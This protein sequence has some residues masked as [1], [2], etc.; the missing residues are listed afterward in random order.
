MIM[1]KV[2]ASY[3]EQISQ[4]DIMLQALKSNVDKLSR[5]GIDQPFVDEME[6][7]A[8]QVKALNEE[9]EKLKADLKSKTESLNA[10]MD[11]L[12]GKYSEAKKL[13]KLEIPQSQW[14]EFGI[15]DKR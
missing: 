4:A 10:L 7:M 12:A 14:K 5:R 6:S 2:K 11:G 9:Q 15:N 3:A 13:V 1:A 8:K